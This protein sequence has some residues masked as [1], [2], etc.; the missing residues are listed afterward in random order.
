MAE[1]NEDA[2]GIS[3]PWVTE[4]S[5]MCVF[6]I[7]NYSSY[8][9]FSQNPLYSCRFRTPVTLFV[10]IMVNRVSFYGRTRN[11]DV[12]VLVRE[13][14]GEDKLCGEGNGTLTGSASSPSTSTRYNNF[15]YRD[16]R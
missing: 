11:E 6:F 16:G 7:V 8:I 1:R 10:L 9:T 5:R 15:R 2:G 12:R 3:C 14:E 13:V 4:E